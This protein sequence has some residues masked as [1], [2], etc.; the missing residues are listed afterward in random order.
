VNSE[1]RATQWNFS[2]QIQPGL[3]FFAAEVVL[4]VGCHADTEEAGTQRDLGA[5]IAPCL[6]VTM[7]F[8][9]LL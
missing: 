8:L 1:P 2:L 5:G 6:R 3:L 4:W 9:F 7:I